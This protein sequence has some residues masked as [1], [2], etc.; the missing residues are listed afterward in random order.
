MAAAQVKHLALVLFLYLM[1]FF[2]NPYGVEGFL[3]PFKVIFIP[4]FYDLYKISGMVK[5]MQPPSYIFLSLNYWY[6]LV[7]A[8][9]GF[10]AAVLNKNRLILVVL[11]L[12]SLFAFLTV[13]RNSSFFV[14][15]SAFVIIEG[16]QGFIQKDVWARGRW[17]GFFDTA[18]MTGIVVFLAVQIFNLCSESVFINGKKSR[19]LWLQVNSYVSS[20]I[21][22][23]KENGITGPVF[24]DDLLSNFILW[25]DYPQLRPFDDARHV[26]KERFNNSMCILLKPGI[27]WP[28]AEKDYGF[29]IFIAIQ[30][31]AAQGLIDYIH[32][33][34]DWQLISVRGPILVY[35]KKGAFHLPE[36]LDKFEQRLK[37]VA[38]TDEDIRKLKIISQRKPRAA[39]DEF[40]DPSPFEVDTFS[41]GETLMDLG[42]KGAAAKDFIDASRVSS[43]PYMQETVSGFLKQLG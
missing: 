5:E 27:I 4:S 33:R 26:D 18:I 41:T 15:V 38:L 25:F 7:L 20:S 19:V 6:F 13:A 36:E 1:G 17:L 22:L 28:R 3:Y 16:A 43:Q 42:Y 37:S 12:F 35:V 29:K 30:G 34:P 23:L 2:I 8:A 11:F 10:S 24:T 40:L 21:N 39:W 32:T 31:S 14:L 9:L